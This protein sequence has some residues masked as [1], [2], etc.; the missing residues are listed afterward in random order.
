MSA[1]CISVSHHLTALIQFQHVYNEVL[2]YWLRFQILQPVPTWCSLAGF[3]APASH[4]YVR[5]NKLDFERPS[6]ILSHIFAVT[7]TR[8][9]KLSVLT[10]GFKEKMFFGYLSTIN[11][12]WKVPMESLWCSRKYYCWIPLAV[13]IGYCDLT[14]KGLSHKNVFRGRYLSDYLLRGNTNTLNMTCLKRRE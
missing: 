6:L 8:F 7:A 12:V 4:R 2:S 11:S 3:D 10:F 1:V 9:F 13:S 5:S 14:R